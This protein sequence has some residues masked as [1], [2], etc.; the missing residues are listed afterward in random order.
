[1]KVLITGGLG[2]LGGRLAAHMV[3]QGHKVTVG[4]RKQDLNSK[5]IDQVQVIKTNW[6][7]VDSIFTYKDPFDVVIHAAGMNA[8]DCEE[9]PD[10]AIH[11]NGNITSELV[12]AS[13]KKKVRKFIYLSTAHVYASPLA[14]IIN[15]SSS[16]TN[17]HPYATSHLLGEQAVINA[18][19]N[20][21]IDGK[22]IRISNAFGYPERLEAN[23][24]MLLINDLCRQAVINKKI[25][26]RS[27]G[28]DLRDFIPIT[29]ACK[30]ITLLANIRSSSEDQAIYNLGGMVRS[31][32]EISQI[33]RN[34]YFQK[35]EETLEI[36]KLTSKGK[37]IIQPL[38]YQ[39]NWLKDKNYERSD[40]NSLLQEINTLLDYCLKVFKNP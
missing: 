33:I 40:E 23:C 10:K 24:W 35:T 13:I 30:A 7:D 34:L 14:G 18:N 25:V 8:K 29:D 6:N 9:Q 3:Q 32:A 5:I 12:H 16:T 36:E 21:K 22:V 31:V 11:F 17:Q 19:K 37:K 2:F 4:S 20:G 26:L 28:T 39:M 1:M 27:D 38:E 15:E